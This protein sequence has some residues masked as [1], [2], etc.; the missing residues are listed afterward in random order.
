MLVDVKQGATIIPSAGVQRGSQGTYAYVVKEDH[1]VTLRPLKV[2]QIQG[3]DTAIDAGLTP[4]ELVV[5]DG[6]DKLRE[7]A[8][9]EV[10]QKN[11]KAPRAM[12]GSRPP[13]A[14][15]GRRGAASQGSASTPGGA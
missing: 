10:S 13:G 1:S 2:G 3:D 6:A 4:G 8:K 15:G 9:V 5:V 11:G 14:G 12:D 7:G